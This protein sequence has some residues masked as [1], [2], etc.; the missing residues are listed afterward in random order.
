[1]SFGERGRR[2][3]RSST[4]GTGALFEVER[5]GGRT[6]FRPRSSSR[7]SRTV[8]ETSE[9]KILEPLLDRLEAIGKDLTDGHDIPS[10]IIE[11]GLALWERYLQQLHDQHIGQFRLAGPREDHPD[12][13]ALP[14][15][16]IESD[17]D[18]SAYR[19]GAMWSGY[20]LHVGGYR[21]LLGLIRVGEARAE[22]AWEG[23][24]EDYAKTCLPTHLTPAAVRKWTIAVDL[25]Q[26][27]IPLLRDKVPDYLSRTA[28]YVGLTV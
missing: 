7:G 4:A 9:S 5:R 14:L 3:A 12:R 27:E 11:E 10:E 28:T 26:K 24:E 17:S 18:R 23:L 2:P 19:I 13:C 6:R 25:G 8:C 21:E 16:D 20:N 22:R 15:I 1:M